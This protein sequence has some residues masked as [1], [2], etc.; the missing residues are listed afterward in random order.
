MVT[1][2]QFMV[3]TGQLLNFDGTVR[4]YGTGRWLYLWINYHSLKIAHP[5]VI[6]LCSSL[7]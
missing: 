1:A 3:Y 7:P 2:V 4:V 6:T 5:K